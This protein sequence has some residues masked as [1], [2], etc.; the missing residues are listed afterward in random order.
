MNIYSDDSIFGALFWFS[1]FAVRFVGASH[2][3]PKESFF[4][5]T[6]EW[7]VEGFPEYT[8]ESLDTLRAPSEGGPLNP[9][10]RVFSTLVSVSAEFLCGGASFCSIRQIWTRTLEGEDRSNRGVAR[11]GPCVKEEIT[12]EERRCILLEGDFRHCRQER[13]QSF[14]EHRLYFF[15]RLI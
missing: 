11:R 3:P 9:S 6:F 12:F 10:F 4:G 13:L 15:Y 1:N 5:E 8:R 2:I 7:S 14:Y